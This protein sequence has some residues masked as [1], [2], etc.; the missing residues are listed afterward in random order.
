VGLYHSTKR[1]LI[2]GDVV[3]ADYAIGRF[4]LHGA[5]GPDLY[6]SLL[7]LAELDVEILLPGHNRIVED[8]PEGYIDRTARQWKSY[9][10]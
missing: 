1:A 3:Y 9:L 8:L 6:K 4:D 2:P 7:S 10:L 5:S